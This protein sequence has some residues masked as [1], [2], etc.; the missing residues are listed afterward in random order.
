VHLKDKE[1][2]LSLKRFSKQKVKKLGKEAQVLKERNL[3]KNVIKPSA[4]VPEILCTCVD[5]TFAAI[6]LNTTLACPISSLLHSPLDESSVRF[7]TGSLVSAI[8]DIHK[9]EILFRGSSPELL[10]LDQSGYLQ[11]CVFPLHGSL[12]FCIIHYFHQIVILIS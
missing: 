12:G 6:L 5:Q 4:I 1:N 2:L 7:I 10:M 9:N 3:M 8:E 11:V